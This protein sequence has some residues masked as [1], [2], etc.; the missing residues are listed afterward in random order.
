MTKLGSL[1][2]SPETLTLTPVGFGQGDRCRAGLLDHPLADD[3]DAPGLFRQRNEDVGCDQTPRWMVP[4][5]KR[6]QRSNFAMLDADD[7]L[8]FKIEF[9]ID[10]A[11]RQVALE[12]EAIHHFA[13]Q[14]LVIEGMG[15][16]EDFLRAVE[17]EIGAAHQRLDGA[18]V[19]SP[20]RRC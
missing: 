11:T 19:R 18:P 2:W 4:T 5:Q 6:L 1:N 7:R 14:R 3:L 13:G 15:R 12:F 20:S 17:R 10:E 16:A 9:A 8:V